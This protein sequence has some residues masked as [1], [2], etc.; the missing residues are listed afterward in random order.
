[1]TFNLSFLGGSSLINLV[2]LGWLSLYM[3]L[4]VWI[5]LYRYFVLS[6]RIAKEKSALDLIFH[7][8]E[9]LPRNSILGMSL[10]KTPRGV[11]ASMLR[12]CCDT[13][14]REATV[15]LT[16]L[17]IVAST[18]P[19]IG[20][21]GTVVEILE[22]FSKLGDGARASLDVIAPVIS[23]ALIATA[24]GILTAI[25]AYTF[26]LILK[27]KIFELNSLVESQVKLL[28]SSEENDLSE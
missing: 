14:L 8:Q 17:A 26:H 22:A 28:V 9:T 23:K 15:G 13:T 25:P 7:G 5:F 21:F 4:V 11:T 12:F 6:A 3:I 27:R 1:M 19:F 24:A 10:K 16:F 20:L 18:A 2:V